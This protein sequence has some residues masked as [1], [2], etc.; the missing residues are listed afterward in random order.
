MYSVD[1]T[2]FTIAMVRD[3][4]VVT[5]S[6]F[7]NEK[8][9]ECEDEYASVVVGPS[10]LQIP[11][12]PTFLTNTNIFL[13]SFPFNSSSMSPSYSPSSKRSYSRRS[14]DALHFNTTSL[15]S[16]ARNWVLLQVSTKNTVLTATVIITGKGSLSLT[17]TTKYGMFFG[18]ATSKK[19]RITIVP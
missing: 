4:S 1:T 2:K 8:S 19:L 13:P 7:G 17:I 16:V 12:I 15:L 11:L 3:S 6:S 18:V 10:P 9:M 14:S 5:K